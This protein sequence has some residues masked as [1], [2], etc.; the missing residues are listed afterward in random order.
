MCSSV[1]VCVFVREFASVCERLAV[2]LSVCEPVCVCVPTMPLPV[3]EVP[4]SRRLTLDCRFLLDHRV[5]RGKRSHLHLAVSVSVSLFLCSSILFPLLSSY[6]CLF[7]S[8]W[9][10]LF[11]HSLSS[12]LLG[13]LKKN[14]G[15]IL[16]YLKITLF[17]SV[18][19]KT[20]CLEQ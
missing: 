11:P 13:Q 8:L 19:F 16:I 10:S 20:Y 18:N 6:N 9:L 4:A 3:P 2:C 7:V 12:C 14:V 1:S 5:G 17:E 15:T